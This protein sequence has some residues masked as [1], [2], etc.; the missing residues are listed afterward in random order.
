VRQV[1]RA[2]RNHVDQP[3]GA[4][5]ICPKE[6][7]V[8]LI[9]VPIFDHVESTAVRPKTGLIIDI[10]LRH[11]ASRRRPIEV[12][13]WANQQRPGARTSVLLFL[14]S[15]VFSAHA[16]TA[17]VVAARSAV[18]KLG[19]PRSGPWGAGLCGSGEHV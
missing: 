11:P 7:G 18:S 8:R 1:L 17:Q 14:L 16:A 10:P 4:G 6:S 5:Q 2:G 12:Q 13:G 9:R 19:R 15:V 3:D